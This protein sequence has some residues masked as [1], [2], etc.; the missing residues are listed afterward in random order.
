MNDSPYYSKSFPAFDVSSLHLAM[1]I[2]VWWDLPSFAFLMM[3]KIFSYAY[4]PSLFLFGDMLVSFPLLWQ[5]TWD[6]QFKK[7][8]RFTLALGFRDFSQWLLGLTALGLWLP[9]TSG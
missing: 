6:K 1:A 3:L 9:S 2:D 8:E 5:N 4:L 7:E